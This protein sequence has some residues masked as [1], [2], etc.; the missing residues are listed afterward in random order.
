MLADKNRQLNHGLELSADGKTLYASSSD[1]VFSWDYDATAAKRTTSDPVT[2]VSGM[3]NTDHTTRTLLLS[4]KNPGMIIVSRGST[5]NVDPLALD[6]NS[7]HSQIKAFN[8][9]AR[10]GTTYDFVRNGALLGWGLRN[11]VGVAE[12]P[13]AGGIWS[14]ENSVDNMDRDGTDVHQDNP[15]EELNFHGYLNGT[16]DARQGSNYGYPN[17]Y[18][19]WDTSEIPRAQ[20]LGTGTQFSIGAQNA[21]NNDD[22]CKNNF[23]APIITFPAHTAPLD[24]K[25][26]TQGTAAW[27]TFHGSWYVF[28]SYYL[29]LIPGFPVC[30]SGYFFLLPNTSPHPLYQGPLT[31]QP[32]TRNRNPPIGYKLSY[33]EYR[34]GWPTASA[35]SKTAAI[36][37]ITHKDLSK[38]P[39]E[40]VR[41]VGLAWDSKGRLF[42]SSDT[43]GEIWVITR[44]DGGSVN[45]ATQPSQ[46]GS[47]SPATSSQ[48]SAAAPALEGSSFAKIGAVAALAVGAVQ[49]LL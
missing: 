22:I 12:D 5:E 41:P 44:N 40:C 29:L 4:R 46:T 14:V 3:A 25:F 28:L 10:N 45:T 26:N 48:A 11:S 35:T 49:L 23:T 8:L 24:I 30:F 6:I 21:T 39:G 43:T 31:K 42:M 13:T 1:A 47:G 20:S 17:C 34:N 33:V 36:D 37:V 9:T 15:G 16:Q 18:A 7:G 2:L 32:K 38:C 27:V 19:A